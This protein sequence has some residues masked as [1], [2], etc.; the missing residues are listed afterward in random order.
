MTAVIGSTEES[1]IDPLTEVLDMREE[2]KRKVAI[3]NSI[4]EPR[5]FA[6]S[7]QD[8][9]THMATTAAIS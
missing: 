7:F 4:N 9:T 6:L 8:T 2:F 1:A 3:K 5:N